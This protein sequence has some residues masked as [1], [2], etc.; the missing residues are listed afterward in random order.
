MKKIILTALLAL[1]FATSSL[2]GDTPLMGFAGCPGGAWYPDSQ[3]CCMPNE[4]CPTGRLANVPTGTTKD[5]IL[6]ELITMLKN[7][8]F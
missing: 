6:V 8:Y 2:A 7:I 4:Q 3:V 5:I 1:T